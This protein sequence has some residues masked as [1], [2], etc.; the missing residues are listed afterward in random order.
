MKATL[1]IIRGGPVD[2]SAMLT[3][4]EDVGRERFAMIQRQFTEWWEHQGG[5]LIMGHLDLSVVDINLDIS[6]TGVTLLKSP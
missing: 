1:T 6:G 5:V 4:S 3:L 2:P